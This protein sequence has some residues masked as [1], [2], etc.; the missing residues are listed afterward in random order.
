M[1]DELKATEGHNTSVVLSTPKIKAKLE[2]ELENPQGWLDTLQAD[3]AARS[4]DSLVEL[5]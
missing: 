1:V 3:D 4:K 5:H 2:A